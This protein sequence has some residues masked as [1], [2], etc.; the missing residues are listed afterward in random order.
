MYMSFLSKKIITLFLLVSFLAIALF[1]FALMVHGPDGRMPGDCPFSIMGDSLCPQDTIAV[2]IHNISA[3]HTFL[4]VPVSAGLTALVISLLF[5]IYAVL[6]ISVRLLLFRPPAFT[7]VLYD[8]QPVDS[9][10]NKITR[11][12][13]LLENSPSH[14]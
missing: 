9:Y 6:V 8:S 13:S 1:S 10:S 14:F 2:A 5:A 3:Y 12:L 4:N 11:W 7:P